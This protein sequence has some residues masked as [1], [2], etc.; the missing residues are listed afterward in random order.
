[1]RKFFVD[2]HRVSIVCTN[3]CQTCFHFAYYSL[4]L[5]TQDYSYVRYTVYAK[6]V[7]GALIGPI[8]SRYKEKE[9]RKEGG[10][11]GGSR[12]KGHNPPKCSTFPNLGQSW[13]GKKKHLLPH[14]EYVVGT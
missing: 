7:G 3:R 12:K 6:K 4:W 9:G 1:M 13:K 10:K 8:A 2:S 14:N 5:G 11:G